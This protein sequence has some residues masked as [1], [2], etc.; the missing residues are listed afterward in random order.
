MCNALREII[1]RLNHKQQLEHLY[2]QFCVLKEEVGGVW[3]QEGFKSSR[4]DV[5]ALLKSGCG[6]RET[7]LQNYT[8]LICDAG[9][10]KGFD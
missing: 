6:Q 5:I 10:E 4:K 7:A 9:G 3:S 2:L 8:S 1:K